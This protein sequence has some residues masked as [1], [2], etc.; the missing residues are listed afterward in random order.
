MKKSF[1]MLLAII[2]AMLFVVNNS[3]YGQWNGGPHDLS[4][5]TSGQT[6][7][8]YAGTSPTGYYDKDVTINGIA[9]GANVQFPIGTPGFYSV[10]GSYT[11]GFFIYFLLCAVSPT[12]LSSLP[13]AEVG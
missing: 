13:P 1:K 4:G 12:I 7:D 6:Y 11:N 2:A 10:G 3:T 9:Y 8:F 5:T